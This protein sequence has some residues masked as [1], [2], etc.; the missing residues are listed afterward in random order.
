MKLDVE[1]N[2]A[3]SRRPELSM[4]MHLGGMVVDGLRD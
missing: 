4:G 2:D 1:G 3:N